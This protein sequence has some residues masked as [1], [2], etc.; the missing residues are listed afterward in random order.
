MPPKAKVGLQL[1]P[2][3]MKKAMASVKTFGQKAGKVMGKVAP[4]GAGMLGIG[5]VYAIQGLTRETMQYDMRLQRLGIQ[6][7]LTA[8]EQSNLNQTILD[9]STDTGIARDQLLDY[10]QSVTD[11]TG[12]LNIAKDAVK[13][14]A[15]GAQAT[16]ADLYGLGQIVSDLGTKYGLMGEKSG[17]ALDILINQGAM[18]KLTLNEMASV[19]PKMFSVA[20]AAFGGGEEGLRRAGAYA[21]I[22]RQGYGDASGTVTAFQSSIQRLT[23]S[24]GLKKLEKHGIAIKGPGGQMRSWEDMFLDVIAKSQES[25]TILTDVLGES[26]YSGGLQFQKILEKSEWSMEGLRKEIDKY[27]NVQGSTR[28]LQLKFNKASESSQLKL[29]KFKASLAANVDKL[30][31][32]EDAL[33]TLGGAFEN[34]TI[35]ANWMG[36]E[37]KTLIDDWRDLLGLDDRDNRTDEQLAK[38]SLAARAAAMNPAQETAAKRIGGLKTHSN[39][40]RAFLR[41]GEEAFFRWYMEQPEFK[42][43][44]RL[45][46]DERKRG[47]AW[48]QLR[49]DR[50]FGSKKVSMGELQERYSEHLVST[51]KVSPESMLEHQNRLFEELVNKI[52]KAVEKGAEKGTSKATINAPSP[53]LDAGGTQ[54][55]PAHTQ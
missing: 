46:S 38:D 14:V 31:L 48:R 54:A 36:G 42:K 55:E 27:A 47:I 17:K 10:M 25:S 7:G 51:G 49:E 34:L 1:G 4:I 53:L 16:G 45:E 18:G 28:G 3:D 41:P 13:Y 15:M 24:E 35:S 52:E 2:V 40:D 50:V 32:T 39:L 8:K 22:M 12:N 20:Q 11:A 29:D 9:S 26:A 6:A 23:S 21:Q 33:G 5:G 44:T 43:K 19:G 37:M 30:V